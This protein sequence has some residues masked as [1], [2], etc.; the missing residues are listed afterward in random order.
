MDQLHAHP[1]NPWPV[2]IVH[3]IHLLQAEDDSV[4]LLNLID[5]A[6]PTEVKVQ[7]RLRRVREFV[8]ACEPVRQDVIAHDLQETL[9]VLL[10][11]LC[12]LGRQTGVPFK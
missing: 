12:S 1:F 7:H 8:Q 6:R 5:N 3:T 11:L 2:E 10:D 4:R 9:R